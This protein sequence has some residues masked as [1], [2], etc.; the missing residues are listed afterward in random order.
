[1][2]GVRSLHVDLAEYFFG[3]FENLN[4]NMKTIMKILLTHGKFQLAPLRNPVFPEKMWTLFWTRQF[5]SSILRGGK[6]CRAKNN[7]YIK[8]SRTGVVCGP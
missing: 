6:R 2:C 1:M 3:T 4:T 5:A 8:D 7:R